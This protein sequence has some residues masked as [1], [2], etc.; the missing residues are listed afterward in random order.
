MPKKKKIGVSAPLVLSAV[1]AGLGVTAVSIAL[2]A[3]S[4]PPVVG[5]SDDTS[6]SKSA[7]EFFI[8]FG[9]SYLEA[10]KNEWTDVPGMQVTVDAAAYPSSKRAVFETTIFCPTGNQTIS[11]R[12]RNSEYFSYPELVMQGR[13]PSLLTSKPFSIP[14]K[15]T[16]TVQ[17]KTQ[18]GFPVHIYQ[19]RMKIGG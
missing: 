1:A 15:T 11:M 14:G 13:G 7:R 8:P 2:S 6:I 18:L 4:T 9:Y 16:Y 12:L 10:T 19:A 5:I 17:I 3:R